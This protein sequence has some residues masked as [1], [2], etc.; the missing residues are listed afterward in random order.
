MS[1]LRS[2][3]ARF[4]A[5]AQIA[6]LPAQ[7]LL[8]WP[9]R[10]LCAASPVSPEA[11]LLL[12]WLIACA[13]LGVALL[14]TVRPDLRLLLIFAAPPLFLL[15]P[16]RHPVFHFCSA[17]P[18]ALAGAAFGYAGDPAGSPL[19]LWPLLLVL[20]LLHFGLGMIGLADRWPP[21]RFS[22]SVRRPSALVVETWDEAP[23]APA[24][25]PA[26]LR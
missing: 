6:S 3:F 11:A 25:D 4:D 9:R 7:R 14:A 20:A 1:V 2:L 18:L 24:S 5:F 22:G 12:V 13:V 23:E 21:P 19:P 16:R 8:S 26:L 17:C 10:G 15:V